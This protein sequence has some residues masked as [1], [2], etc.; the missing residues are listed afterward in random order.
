M[1]KSILVFEDDLRI[2]EHWKAILEK[3]GYRVY[4]EADVDEAIKVV[5]EETIDLVLTDIFIL[6]PETAIRPRG[7]LSLLSHLNLNAHPCPKV[8]AITG[9]SPSLNIEA[10]VQT[11]RGAKTLKKPVRDQELLETVASELAEE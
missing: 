5:D 2:A 3:A 4:H 6:N 1:T 9:A 8:I 7:G 10:L 11:F